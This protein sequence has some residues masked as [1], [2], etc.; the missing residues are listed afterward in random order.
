MASKAVSAE[1]LSA[2]RDYLAALQRLGLRPLFLGWGLE[3]ETERWVLG[4]VT[5]IVEAGGPLALNRLLFKA[6]NA[7]ATPKDISPFIVRVY[8]PEIAP[9]E[10]YLLADKDI[11]INS[12]NQEV[13]DIGVSN[14]QF[15]FLGV[16]YERINACI[17][18]RRVQRP[19]YHETREEWQRFKR[20]VEKLA[21]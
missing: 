13:K 11:K 2:S 5:S 6:Y 20:N 9:N 10:F 16:H 14:V 1:Y 17:I 18:P 19:K 21:A 7:K 15:D 8:S 4:V 3:T 12:V